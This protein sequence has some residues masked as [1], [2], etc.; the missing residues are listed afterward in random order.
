M[1]SCTGSVHGGFGG[2]W[3]KS[4]SW[5]ESC[6]GRRQL[7]F[8]CSPWPCVGCAL[9]LGQMEKSGVSLSLCWRI[10]KLK[11]NKKFRTWTKK[12]S[13]VFRV[14]VFLCS[15]YI[16][17]EHYNVH[18]TYPYHGYGI[19]PSSKFRPA[20]ANFKPAYGI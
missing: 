17:Y 15:M 11:G 9:V 19:L 14:S 3:K 16:C 7:T 8:A 5:I 10:F 18:F 2:I 4:V 1:T 13:S 6:L 20:I 12:S